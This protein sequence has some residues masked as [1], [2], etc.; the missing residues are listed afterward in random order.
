MTPPT[1]QIRRICGSSSTGPV[2]RGNGR[3][4]SLTS[5]ADVLA[6]VGLVPLVVVVAARIVGHRLGEVAWVERHRVVGG[7][8]VDGQPPVELE[9]R[10]R[11]P[12]VA[13]RVPG[14]GDPGGE[15]AVAGRA[16]HARHV[17]VGAL[18]IAAELRQHVLD[19]ALRF[20][21]VDERRLELAEDLRVAL[22]RQ[23]ALRAFGVERRERLLDQPLRQLAQRQRRGARSV[24]EQLPFV[25]AP[26]AL[27]VAECR[28]E[29]DG[30]VGHGGPCRQSGGP[31][32]S[33]AARRTGAWKAVDL[34]EPERGA[35]VQWVSVR[36]SAGADGDGK[37]NAG[38]RLTRRTGGD[39][40]PD[41]GAGPALATRRPGRP[42]SIA[43]SGGSTPW[44]RA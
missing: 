23:L 44:W 20:R 25:Q 11:V 9:H 4:S 43:T 26:P 14:V 15:V 19:V 32:I 24:H 21:V 30:V 39:R 40:R 37:A 41:V 18:E 35:V 27:V 38:R 12:G 17:E 16:A 8:P 3:G 2:G 13:V 22:H 36:T 7:D 5:L 31:S 10:R 34:V 6:A 28:I 33:G 29:V 42:W 1:G